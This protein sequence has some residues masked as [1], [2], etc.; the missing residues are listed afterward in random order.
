M[1][2][3]R[4]FGY[5]RAVILTALLALP[6]SAGAETLTVTLD[7]TLVLRPSEPVSVVMVGNPEIADV[8]AESP[9][10]IFVIGLAAGETNLLMLDDSG[11]ELASYDVVVVPERERHVTVHRGADGVST[12]SCDPRC[13]G[14]ENPGTE[15]AGGVAGGTGESEGAAAAIGEAATAAE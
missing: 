9:R 3:K 6:S 7:K 13:T 8:T 10:L 15:T 1:N 12:L 14:V 5:V 2:R 11:K 4:I